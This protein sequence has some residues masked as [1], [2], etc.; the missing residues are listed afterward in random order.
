[1]TELD[2][3]IR[4]WQK[5][6]RA[7]RILKLIIENHSSTVTTDIRNYL[8]MSMNTLIEQKDIMKAEGKG[9]WDSLPLDKD[10]V[11]AFHEAEGLAKSGFPLRALGFVIALGF[12]EVNTKKLEE[13]MNRN[14]FG[15]I[16]FSLMMFRDMLQ[17]E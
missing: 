6:N 12:E 7:I 14:I 9:K 4:N 2:M 1:M 8:H 10:M 5:I 17:E 3:D 15:D 16:I 11:P 13:L